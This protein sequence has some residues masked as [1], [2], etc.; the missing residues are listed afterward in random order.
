[1]EMTIRDDF[2]CFEPADYLIKKILMHYF[3][4]EIAGNF[5][6]LPSKIAATCG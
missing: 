4:T 5:R 6:H 3:F 1:M 2:R